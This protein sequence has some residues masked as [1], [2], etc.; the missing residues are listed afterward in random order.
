MAPAI[1]DQTRI[2]VQA[3]SEKNIY[4]LG[5]EGKIIKFNGWLAAYGGA[6][7]ETDQLPELKTGDDLDLIK[8]NPEQKF[9]AP[10][11]RYTEASLIK[12]LEELGIGR[13]STYAPIV[14]TIQ[15]RQ[16]VEKIE[17]KF[18]PTALGTTVNDFLFDYFPEIID[19][20]FTARMEDSL[21]SIANGKIAWQ[22]VISDFYGPFEKKLTGVK[23]VAER[24][25]VPTEATGE[26][27]PQCK[28]G[29]LVIRLG[30]FGKFISCSR[31]PDCKYTAPFIQKLEGVKC[32][33]CGGEIV[34]R[35]TKKGKQFYGCS[36]YPKCDWAS[37]RKPK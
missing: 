10:L 7:S 20:D 26:K 1:W 14:S 28:E 25:K 33:K 8:I 22:P 32:P 5:A 15:D 2:N 11:P 13:P 34:V 17:G 23:E 29:Q 31:F 30:R 19:Y 4:M 6:K 35:K 36:N 18:Q 37:W 3:S 12:A 21:D 9:T 16:Y 24:A 27:C